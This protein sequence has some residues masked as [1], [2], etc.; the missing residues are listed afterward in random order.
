MEGRRNDYYVPWHLSLKAEDGFEP[1]NAE[2]CEARAAAMGGEYDREKN[3]IR[4]MRYCHVYEKEELCGLARELEPAAKIV[5]V[6]FEK[7]NW[8]IELEKAG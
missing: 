5:N 4:L 1:G 6:F 3:A 2:D 8:A 7:S